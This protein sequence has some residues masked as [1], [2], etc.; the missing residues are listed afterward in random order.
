[1]FDCEL[2]IVNR[3]MAGPVKDRPFLFS[4][5]GEGCLAEIAENAE[6]IR[7]TANLGHTES[8][9]FA[10]AKEGNMGGILS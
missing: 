9:S 4:L 5:D 8:T 3:K 7:L 6:M 10:G 1:M 2:C